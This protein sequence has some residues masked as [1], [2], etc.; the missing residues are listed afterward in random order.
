MKRTNWNRS[1]TFTPG[2]VPMKRGESR[3]VDLPHDFMIE[4]KRDPANLT[5]RDGAY[6]PGGI[7]WY[8][9][10]FTAPEE[11]RDKNVYVEFEGVYMNAEVTLN[12]NMLGRQNYGYTTFQLC[13]DPYLKYGGENTLEVFV[14]NSAVPNS[15]WYSGSG[16]YRPVWLYVA[17]KTHIDFGGVYVKTLAADEKEAVLKVEVNYTSGG[18]ADVEVKHTIFDLTDEK[19]IPFRQDGDRIIVRDPKLWDID[20]PHLY[21]L[22]TVLRQNG[23]EIDSVDTVFGIRTVSL[24]PEKGFVLNGKPVKLKGG[25]IHHDNGLLGAESY[26][27]SEERKVELMK[28]C[29]YNAVR[30]AHNPHAPAFLDACD[31]L[32]MIVLDE[33]F[34]QWRIAKTQYDYHRVF[35]TDYEHDMSAMI[36]RDRNHPSVAFWS[37]GNEIPEQWGGSS[38]PETAKKLCAIVHRFDDRPITMGLY[39]TTLDKTKNDDDFPEQTAGVYTVIRNLDFVGYNYYYDKYA[40][41]HKKHPERVIMSTET[42]P[43][44]IYKSWQAVLDNDFVIGD[45]VWTAIDYLGEVALGCSWYKDDSGRRHPEWHMTEYPWHTANCGDI[46]VCGFKRPQSFYRDILWGVSDKP[47]LF[48]R[49][50]SADSPEAESVSFWGWHDSVAGWDFDVP[51]G[52]PMIV[53]VYSPAAEVSLWQNGEPVG[54][55]S[56]TENQTSFVVPYRKGTLRI[57]DSN[58]NTDEVKTAGKPVALRLTP[59]RDEIGADGDL[60]YI[61]AEIVDEN[62]QRVTSA[63]PEVSF[64]VSGP[65]KIAAVG[66]SDPKSEEPYRGSHHRAYDGRLMCVVRSCGEG[67][68]TVRAVADGLSPAKTIVSAK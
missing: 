9:K 25:C 23:E 17:E 34:D 11:W 16:I 51:E 26:P 63:N 48:V 66:S 61:T 8:A 54:T 57:V 5:R 53:D 65:A 2:T 27:R 28:Q 55:N 33:A 50:Q 52:S 56:L 45:F 62:G 14:D 42:F 19:E 36:L 47:K 15:R 12:G 29:G 59:D 30:T 39:P 40:N 6:Y 3:P 38:A 58:G 35:D 18:S 32:G 67:S 24:S 44:E 49:R 60:C 10:K 4:S 37:I 20:A 68:V 1:W 64:A 41:I 43:K 22:T 31:R 21:R 46:D 7:G 13:L